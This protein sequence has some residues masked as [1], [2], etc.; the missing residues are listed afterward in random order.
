MSQS[1]MM[2]LT[3]MVSLTPWTPSLATCRTTPISAGTPAP[4][5]GML[6]SPHIL[7]QA[8]H[9]KTIELPRCQADLKRALATSGA[10]VDAA[11]LARA[12]RPAVI[13]ARAWVVAVSFLTV[14]VI[15]GWAMSSHVSLP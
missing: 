7:R 6:T 3:L 10:E 2:V 13:N 9:C 12:H 14:G 4:C 1:V 8:L 5:D 15:V 11:L